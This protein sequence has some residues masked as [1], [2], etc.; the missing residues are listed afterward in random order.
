MHRT[1]LL[2]LILPLALAAAVAVAQRPPIAGQQ[3]RL[4]CSDCISV[5]ILQQCGFDQDPQCTADAY[6]P[7]QDQCVADGSC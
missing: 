6:G 4:S 1:R 7:C 2:R 3:T 5:C